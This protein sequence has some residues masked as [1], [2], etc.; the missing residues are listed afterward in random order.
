VS[1]IFGMNTAD[2]RNQKYTQWVFWAAAI[3][4]T[5]LV[6]LASLWGADALPSLSG[7]LER[8]GKGVVVVG[9]G[10]VERNEMELELEEQYESRERAFYRERERGL[11]YTGTEGD[12]FESMR[13]RRRGS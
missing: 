1:S 3:P 13:R 4:L 10:E 5:L 6:V 12:R 8:S 9:D 2:I 7:A 11:S